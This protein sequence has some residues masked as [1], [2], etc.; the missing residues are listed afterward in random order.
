MRFSTGKIF[1]EEYSGVKG[2]PECGTII[3]AGVFSFDISLS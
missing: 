2:A 3:T 1:V